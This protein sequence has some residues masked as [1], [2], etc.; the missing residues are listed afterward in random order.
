MGDFNLRLQSNPSGCCI[1][2]ENGVPLFRFEC[3]DETDLTEQGEAMCH[4][5]HALAAE[6][7]RRWN[8]CGR[9]EKEVGQLERG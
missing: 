9:F 6:V 8:W 4:R 7:V 2:D 1:E 5:C 3:P